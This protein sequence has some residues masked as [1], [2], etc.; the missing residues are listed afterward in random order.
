MKYFFRSILF[1]LLLFSSCKKEYEA[2]AG[3][4]DLK[5]DLGSIEYQD[6][7]FPGGA[8]FFEYNYD[9]SYAGVNGVLVY[10]DQNMFNAYECTC[11]LDHH[12]PLFLDE[13]GFYLECECCGSL[14]NI[15]TGSGDEGE[16]KGTF[17]R[18]Y[19]ANYDGYYLHVRNN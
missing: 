17:L 19:K 3:Y 14:F 8:H 12:C 15:I 13:S 5:I 18:R 16:A 9:G 1:S 7:L 6:L 2:P 4:V 10:H 11:P